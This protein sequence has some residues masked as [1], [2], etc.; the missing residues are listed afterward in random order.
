MGVQG[1]LDSYPDGDQL[2]I[3]DTLF[4]IERNKSFEYD[5]K[6]LESYT[7]EIEAR[8]AIQVQDQPGLS[9]ETLSKTKQTRK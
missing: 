7:W 1:P 5:S 9:N 8:G 6:D 2:E 3:C 4:Q